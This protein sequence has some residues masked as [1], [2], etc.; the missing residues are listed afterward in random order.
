MDVKFQLD[1]LRLLAAADRSPELANAAMVQALRDSA[2]TVQE[3]AWSDQIHR[4]RTRTSKLEK[5]VEYTVDKKAMNATVF[6]NETEAPYGP[7]VHEGTKPHRITV[8]PPGRLHKGYPEKLTKKGEPGLWKGALRFVLNGKFAFRRAVRHPGTKKDQF[9][10]KAGEMAQPQ[11][12]IIFARALDDLAA[13]LDR[14]IGG[15]A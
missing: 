10:Y 6:L 2:G 5:S 3:L 12:N 15:G 8:Q 9:L 4:F 11:I 1:Y 13:Q 14:Q 7:W